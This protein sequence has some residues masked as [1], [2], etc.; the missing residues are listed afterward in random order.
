MIEVCIATLV[1]H[2][3]GFSAGNNDL[4]NFAVDFQQLTMKGWCNGVH[5]RAELRGTL[6]YIDGSRTVCRISLSF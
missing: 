5:I 2:G 3:I 4:R 6:A 1:L